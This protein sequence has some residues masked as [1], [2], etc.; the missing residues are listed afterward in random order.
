MQTVL[1][2][3]VTKDWSDRESV[4]RPISRPPAGSFVLDHHRRH[5]D[6]RQPDRQPRPVAAVAELSQLAGGGQGD[7]DQAEPVVG[8]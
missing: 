8:D 1:L 7:A 3:L 4:A 2:R 6:V 5:Q